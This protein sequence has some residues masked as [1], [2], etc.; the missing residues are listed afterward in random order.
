MLTP[1][2]LA[3]AISPVPPT[4]GGSTGRRFRV[5][6]VGERVVEADNI[7]DAITQVEALGATEITSIARE[8]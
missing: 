1:E 4:S 7:R 2:P 6:F 5:T 3:A 8:T